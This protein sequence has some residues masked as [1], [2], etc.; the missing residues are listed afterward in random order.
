M[1]NNNIFPF[2]SIDASNMLS[3]S[4][5]FCGL[6][7]EQQ[8]EI[9]PE[10]IE[11]TEKYNAEIIASIADDFINHGVVK[12]AR[13]LSVSVDENASAKDTKNAMHYAIDFIEYTPENK[14]GILYFNRKRK[15]F[16]YAEIK[17]RFRK[18]F[19]TANKTPDD[20]YIANSVYGVHAYGAIKFFINV[21]RTITS[22]NKKMD[23]TIITSP[24]F[25]DAHEFFKT[26]TKSET[27]E[28]PFLLNNE[29]SVSNNKKTKMITYLLYK[30]T[31]DADFAK[32]AK[33]YH[34]NDL[35]SHIVKTVDGV[36]T[37]ASAIDILPY[38]I[39]IIVM[40]EN[41][42]QYADKNRNETKTET[43]AN[44]ELL[45]IVS[46][47]APEKEEETPEKETETET[48]TQTPETE[49][50]TA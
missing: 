41:G 38:I 47:H 18:R 31:D 33:Y 13:T 26:L 5:Y 8:K 15:A 29:K 17:K 2:N 14:N 20:K 30:L 10:I 35:V 3:I 4:S 46:F 43:S 27:I 48:E 22:T 16:N 7:T 44:N 50:K 42:I 1:T 37:T 9:F 32:K 19:K 24:Y 21:V 28:N 23:D 11:E 36:T 39:N 34:F 6:T 49:T 40:I 12:H 45:P 25:I